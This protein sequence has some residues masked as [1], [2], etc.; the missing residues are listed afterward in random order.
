LGTS[1]YTSQYAPSATWTA[2]SDSRDKTNIE[3]LP[4]GLEFIR[5]VRPV[6]FTWQ[7][8]D[9]DHTH[10]RWNMPDSGFIAQELL[11]LIEKYQVKDFLKLAVDHDPDKIY[12]DPGRLLPVV[13]KAVQE[14]ADLNDAY[15]SRVTELEARLN[16]GL[17][18]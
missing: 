2:L 15:T 9:T 17:G 14:L 13:V 16:T 7:I 12:A 10:P 6:K 1:A 5:Q 11:A 8:R 4:V 18:N 3:D